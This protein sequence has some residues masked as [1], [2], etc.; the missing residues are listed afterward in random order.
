MNI[1]VAV[2]TVSGKAYYLIVNEL[3]K[4]CI[5]F[6]SLTPKDPIPIYIKVVITTGT[7]K[8]LINHEK[9]LVVNDEVK[10]DCLINEV[11]RFIQG[12]KYYEQI[13]IGIDPGKVFGLA[14]L[15]DGKIVETSNCYNI[16]ET[17]EKTKSIINIFKTIPTTLFSVKVGNGV[18]EYNKKLLDLLNKELP[19]N[20]MLE[21]VSET[22]TNRY[23]NKTEHKRSLRNIIS[24][25]KIAGRKGYV[26]ARD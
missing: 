21:S 19:L 20:V 25:I 16:N 3:K 8:C 9:I 22:R 11:L 2:V 18:R 7:E 5:P 10:L 6:L 17:L 12:K 1:E 24:A 15:A 23:N 14:V 13:I 4:R 26:L